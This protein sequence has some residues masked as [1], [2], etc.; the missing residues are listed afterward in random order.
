MEEPPQRVGT[1]LP[2]K[3]VYHPHA[4][5][6]AWHLILCDVIDT[7]HSRSDVISLPAKD[8]TYCTLPVAD[9]TSL[10]S[11]HK[12]YTWGNGPPPLS[13]FSAEEKQ[14]GASQQTQPNSRLK[15]VVKDATYMHAIRSQ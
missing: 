6:R 12:G 4:C 5:P 3:K 7:T 8:M 13:R 10:F 2:F 11:Q 15:V 14:D 1:S 9:M